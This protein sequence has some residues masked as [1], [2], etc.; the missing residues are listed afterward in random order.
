VTYLIEHAERVLGVMR[1]KAEGALHER[2]DEQME[3]EEARTIIEAWL[4]EELPDV[5]P[6]PGGTGY[7][8]LRAAVATADDL[9]ASGN[10]V[11][12][13]RLVVDE[14]T[15]YLWDGD[16]WAAAAGGGG[17]GAEPNASATVIGVTKLSAA[18]A[19]SANPIAVG[20]NDTRA[21][22]DQ[23]AGTASIRTLGTGATQA[24]PGNH[25]HAGVYEP[26]GAVGTHGADTTAVHGVTDTAGLGYTLKWD[27]VSNYIPASL[28]TVTERPREFRGP[29]DPLTIGTITMADYDTWV[30][31]V[32]P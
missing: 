31:T 10:R 32:A 24:A 5:P 30:P 13:M 12:D 1:F 11:A 20:T 9:P 25:D 27:G 7:G 3:V 14:M 2:R 4:G 23:A 16:A 28:R 18:P 22:A 21:T 26:A 8:G 29:T 6:P 17:G 19:S 15:L